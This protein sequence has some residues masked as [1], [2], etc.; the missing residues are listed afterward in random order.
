MTDTNSLRKRDGEEAAAKLYEMV[1][2]SL[3]SVNQIHG[4]WGEVYDL[5]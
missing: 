2:V 3:K 1:T 4:I 5:Y